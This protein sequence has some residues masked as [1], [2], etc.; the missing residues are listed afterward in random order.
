MPGPNLS[1]IIKTIDSARDDISVQK[2]ALVADCL[3]SHKLPEY[4]YSCEHIV[5]CL[6]R[7]LQKNSKNSDETPDVTCRYLFSIFSKFRQMQ[8]DQSFLQKYKINK[9]LKINF[10]DENED[11]QMPSNLIE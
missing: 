2:I 3:E 6:M 4:P 10:T 11:V 7:Q 8:F 9:Y 1:Q 5:T